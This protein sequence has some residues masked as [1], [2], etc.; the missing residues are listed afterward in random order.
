MKSSKRN[1][2]QNIN[3]SKQIEV[4]RIVMEITITEISVIHAEGIDTDTVIVKTT[5]PGAAYP[6]EEPLSLK[7]IAPPDLGQKYVETY[8][9]DMEIVSPG[10]PYVT[11]FRNKELGGK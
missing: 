9:P 10:D 7:F 4:E 6:F 3:A 1:L 8:F 5:L 2:G 11:V